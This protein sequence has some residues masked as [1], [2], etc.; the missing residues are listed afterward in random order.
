MKS[1]EEKTTAES[2]AIALF[3]RLSPEAQDKI[4]DLIKALL[5]KK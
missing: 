4:I 3:S 1:D 2:E 5:S